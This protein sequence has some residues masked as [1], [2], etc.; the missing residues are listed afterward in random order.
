MCSCVRSH[1]QSPKEHRRGRDGPCPGA[2]AAGLPYRRGAGRLPRPQSNTSKLKS[3]GIA[4]HFVN[5]RALCTSGLYFLFK[6]LEDRGYYLQYSAPVIPVA[7]SVSLSA[8]HS[9]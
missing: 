1:T 8:L 4:A 9:L 7:F 2:A 6:L 5:N 3:V